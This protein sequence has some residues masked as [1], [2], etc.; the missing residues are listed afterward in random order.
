MACEDHGSQNS[1]VSSVL[2]VN[3]G[4]P[5]LFGPGVSA[6]MKAQMKGLVAL[7]AG[8]LC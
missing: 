5:S 6:Q 7:S 8:K 1:F 3:V 2:I 4:Q